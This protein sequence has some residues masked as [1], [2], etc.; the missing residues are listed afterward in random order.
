M[1]HNA[2]WKGRHAGNDKPVERKHSG[3]E[4]HA[5]MGLGGLDWESEIE[6]H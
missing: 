5:T 2:V 4:S 6:I 3:W 1:P